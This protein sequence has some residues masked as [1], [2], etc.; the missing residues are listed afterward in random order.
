MAE[1]TRGSGNLT[2]SFSF[3]ISDTLRSLM[4]VDKYVLKFF[5]APNVYG[6][7]SRVFCAASEERAAEEGRPSF[8]GHDTPLVNLG[9]VLRNR[10]V[11]Q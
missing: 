1:C 7:A 11:A 3:L 4:Y 8:R 9:Q 2:V 10:S 5:W 6:S